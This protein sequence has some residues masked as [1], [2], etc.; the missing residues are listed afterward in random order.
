[1]L[2]ALP[3][4]GPKKADNATVSFVL[5]HRVNGQAPVLDG[6]VTYTNAAGNLFNIKVLKYYLSNMTLVGSGTNRVELKN[7]QFVNLADAATQNFSFGK[8]PNDNYTHIEFFIGVDSL[9]NSTGTHTGA[10]DPANNM[11]WGW[12]FG[13]RFWLMDGVYEKS[14]GSTSGYGYHVGTNANLVKILLPATLLVQGEEIVVTLDCNI[15][16]FFKGPNPWDIKA[17]ETNHSFPG[18][19]TGAAKLAAN[20]ADMFTISK[21][22]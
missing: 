10:L 15:D 9:A 12:D 1:M 19:E 13:Y 7:Y 22:E 3:A 16:E 18:Q 6:P 11:Y 2:A 14:A 8:I 5:T 17:E 21:I 20:M 4:C